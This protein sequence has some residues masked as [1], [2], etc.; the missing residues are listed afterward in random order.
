MMDIK[1]NPVRF[2]A[3]HKLIDHVNKK[4]NKLGQFYDG[5]IGAEVFLRLENVQGDD[6]KTAEIK[7]LIPGND[8]FVKKQAKTFEEAVNKSIETL[9]LQVTKYKEKLRNQ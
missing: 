5:I 3:D 9:H 8:L 1:V 7:L 6:N 4:V 2:D